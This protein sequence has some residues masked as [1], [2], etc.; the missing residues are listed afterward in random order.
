MSN[1]RVLKH[2]INNYW[3]NVSDAFEIGFCKIKNVND[4]V[5][6]ARCEQKKVPKTLASMNFFNENIIQS[7]VFPHLTMKQ[8]EHH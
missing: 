8:L 2:Q 7:L 4:A 1:T 5:F 3:L 6:K